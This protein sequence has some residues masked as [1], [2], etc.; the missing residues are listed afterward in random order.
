M[1]KPSDQDQQ[2][3]LFNQ[4]IGLGASSKAKSHYPDLIL[5]LKELSLEKEKYQSIFTNAN[6]GIF[7]ADTSGKI[8][9][10]NPAMNR[11]I[12]GN[13][14]SCTLSNFFIQRFLSD[15]FLWT[16]ILVE[17]E[18]NG[19][20]F[21]FETIINQ[22][23]GEE[24]WVSIN[25]ILSKT[26]DGQ[27]IVEGI[28][29]DIT[30]RKKA[31]DE[32]SKTKMYLHS[33]VDSMP[34]ILIGIDSNGY[35]TSLNKQ[36]KI[37]TGKNE[38]DAIG[39]SIGTI[40]KEYS[41]F[42]N[43][44]LAQESHTVTSKKISSSTAPYQHAAITIY[45]LVQQNSEEAIVRIDDITAIEEKEQ[46]LQRAQKMQIT[47][48]L[49]GGIAHDFNNY[50]TGSLGAVSL[51]KT[52]MESGRL[53]DDML[54]K[55]LALIEDASKKSA[56][57]V[58][59]LLTLSR[60]Q[61]PKLTHCS[62]NQLIIS[63]VD[64]FRSSMGKDISLSYEL[65]EQEAYVLADSGQL[66]QVLLNLL[67]N[68]N[69][70]MTIMRKDK[71]HWGGNLD[72]HLLAKQRYDF[73]SGG[74][75]D[76][77]ILKVKDTGTGIPKDIIPDVFNPFFTTKAQ[78]QGTGLG[79]SMAYTIIQEHK[80]NIDI[81]SKQGEGTEV[82][83]TLPAYFPEQE[84]IDDIKVVDETLQGE[85]TV[86]IIDDEKIVMEIAAEIL[87]TC[88]YTTHTASGGREGI[89]LYKELENV[90]A[91]LLDMSMPEMSGK[92]VYEE[93]NNMNPEIKVILASGNP[94]DPR[95]Q[96]VISKANVT[97]QEKPFRLTDLAA[98]IHKVTQTSR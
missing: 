89:R 30:E 14:G 81:Q 56:K 2:D 97:F 16:K 69:H 92:Q 87:S 74:T 78:D 7:R 29:E 86:L 61:D 42:F 51:L 23:Q 71:E 12:C 17:L 15:T 44:Y 48:Q 55:N 80:G 25:L 36:A 39:L 68:A 88:G 4:L 3:E 84:N 1:K 75:S 31:V 58:R 41:D 34:S 62:L 5:K 6:E 54:R 27:K 72:I 79:L 82:T 13:E 67:M 49:A 52:F 95:V 43:E 91:V 18:K 45:P 65:P 21:D 46:Q 40:F 10:I 26:S 28:I 64:L 38:S 35:V 37:I 9:D 50:L 83:I 70:A 20:V 19:A 90:D 96:D 59:Q 33:I 98:T 94:N 73:T 63:T 11:I 32:L 93:L 60:K 66:E 85:G 8:I 24:R 22:S 53:T 77:W 57:M 47:G 76:Y